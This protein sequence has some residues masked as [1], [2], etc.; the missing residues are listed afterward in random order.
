MIGRSPS[1]AGLVAGRCCRHGAGGCSKR[2]SKENTMSVK[3]GSYNGKPTITLAPE[4][5]WPFTFG[6]AKAKLV[7]AN[8]EEIKR[9][10]G[11]SAPASSSRPDPVDL[12][13]E[14]RCKEQCG[15]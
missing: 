12:A 2:Q 7:L 1:H 11:A 8:L 4:S 10:V 6:L 14:D 5:K 3:I 15:L 13:Y 9:F